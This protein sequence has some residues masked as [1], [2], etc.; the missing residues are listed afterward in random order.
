MD[1][2]SRF[3]FTF[4]ATLAFVNFSFPVSAQEDTVEIEEVIVEATR[5][6]E[7]IQDIALSVQALSDEDLADAQIADVSDLTEYIPGFNFYNGLS[8]GVVFSIRGSAPQ[9]IGANSVDSVQAAINGHTVLTADFGEMGFLDLERLEILAGPQGTLYGRNVVGG[10]VNAIT[11][12]PTGDNS[13]FARMEYG[14][15]ASSRLQTAVNLP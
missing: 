4:L 1:K 14:N 7:S 5:R 3:T 13:G 9:A 2:I 15:F 6:A 8:S 10:L 11:A 12:R